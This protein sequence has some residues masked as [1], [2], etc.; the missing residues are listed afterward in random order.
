MLLK[1]HMWNITGSGH[2]TLLLAIWPGVGP[3]WEEGL[4]ETTP[5][6]VFCIMWGQSLAIS[7]PALQLS[8]FAYLI[9]WRMLKK[10]RCCVLVPLFYSTPL[11]GKKKSGLWSTELSECIIVIY[12]IRLCYKALH[13]Q[14]PW[15]KGRGAGRENEFMWFRWT[16]P[17]DISDTWECLWT[18][19][20]LRPAVSWVCRNINHRWKPFHI[21]FWQ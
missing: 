1:K 6:S 14:F 19:I 11:W 2:Y 10:N 9:C 17:N 13:S 21:L 18:S 4:W 3:V 20:F 8:L 16:D 7:L 15:G 5:V 12:G